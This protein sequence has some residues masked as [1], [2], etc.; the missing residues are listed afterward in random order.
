MLT[1]LKHHTLQ[2]TA[3]TG[4]HQ[5]Q[6]PVPRDDIL[7]PRLKQ[8]M[9]PQRKRHM[10]VD[11]KIFAGIKVVDLKEGLRIPNAFLRQPY[12]PFLQNIVALLLQRRH[13]KI[14]HLIQI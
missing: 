8:F 4:I 13:K 11:L 10:A 2:G 5:K 3:R 7:L 14:G 1:A 6:F 9:R 12:A